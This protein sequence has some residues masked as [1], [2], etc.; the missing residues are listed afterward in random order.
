MLLEALQV[1]DE[2]ISVGIIAI[3]CVI[4]LVFLIIW[5]YVAIW[6]YRDAEKRGSSGALWA[7]LVFFFGLI[8][9]IIWFI[10]RPPIRQYGYPGYGYMPPP[11]VY[12][13]CPACGQP[14]TFVAQYGRWYCNQ[15][16]Q[17]K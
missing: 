14:M 8:P 4:S 1:T 16:Q 10:V 13:Y 12:Q 15:C 2:G 17:Y 11:P 9:L 5:I 7:L 3:I 6:V